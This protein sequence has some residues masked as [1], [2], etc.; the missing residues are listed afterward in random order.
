MDSPFNPLLPASIA[1]R[2]LLL[3]STRVLLCLLIGVGILPLLTPRSSQADT[4][5]VTVRPSSGTIEDNY[6]LTVTLRDVDVEGPP[7]IADSD[8]FTVRYMGPQSAIQIVNGIISRQTAFLFEL[9]PT[10]E[11]TLKT[12]VVSITAGGAAIESE[13]LSVTVGSKAVS[14]P[15]SDEIQLSQRTT[16]KRSFVGQ[17][18]HYTLELSTSLPISEVTPPDLT[19]DKFR[20]ESMPDQEPQIDVR[21]GRPI[22]TVSIRRAIFPLSAGTLT[23]PERTLRFKTLDQ[24]MID[25]FPFGL[26]TLFDIPFAQRV[27]PR[28]QSV[29]ASPLT[30]EV[31]SLPAPPPDFPRWD[32][33]APLVGGTSITASY[34]T[35]TI[36]A[37][38]SKTITVSIMTEGVAPEL[39]RV[40]I[41]NSPHYRVY[42]QPVEARSS[43]QNGAL[44]SHRT[45]AITIVPTAG[46]DL[47][48]PPLALGFFDPDSEQYRIATSREI[49][50]SVVGPPPLSTTANGKTMGIARPPSRRETPAVT[51]PPASPLSKK[52]EIGYP[53]RKT[54][55]ASQHLFLTVLFT[56]LL[57]LCVL[58]AARRRRHRSFDADE[59][60]NDLRSA[61]TPDQLQKA[62]DL[63]LTRILT[64]S[65]GS[66]NGENVKSLIRHRVGEPG[67]QFELLDLLD[68]I[69]RE[70]FGPKQERVQ[71]GLSPN[72]HHQ[73]LKLERF[74][75]LQV[76]AIRAIGDLLKQEALRGRA[77]LFRTMVRLIIR[78]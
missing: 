10:R 76:R 67:L 9:T 12:P 74:S 62:I 17:Q 41:E 35:K 73:P 7:Q 19:I 44:V 57:G 1:F 56:G 47:R 68:T 54:V 38:D 2:Y 14:K 34:D 40:F 6:L 26:S 22:Q 52:S 8:D 43:V 77:G 53:V 63:S 33:A 30:I 15:S 60:L 4:L 28:A 78:R 50:F 75:V 61:E 31:A 59:R 46:G 58:F 72:G 29:R 37:G 32:H 71:F 24:A 11:G 69:D 36:K 5:E 21:G 48:I 3:L 51:T 70:R 42:Q 18:I 39:K 49:S 64:T 66:I 25:R 23:I 13:Q 16:P 20:V 55:Q 65:T 45:I 27:R